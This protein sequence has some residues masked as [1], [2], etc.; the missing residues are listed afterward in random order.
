MENLPLS[1]HLSIHLALAALSGYLV[2]HF[3]KQPLVGVIA[4]LLGGFFIDLDHVIEY[5]LVFGPQFS[6]EQFLAGRQF[7]VSSQIFLVFHAWEYAFLL[8]ILALIIKKR[9]PLAAVF[10]LAL[11]F[12]GV[13]HLASDSV[14]NDYPLRNYSVIYRV[15][16]GFQAEQLLNQEQYRQFMETRQY[17]GL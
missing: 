1:L 4:G 13:V 2:G 8:G 12:S 17:F 5:L 11:A 3:S 10:I 16:V 15:R 6:L 14:I 9:W 7:L